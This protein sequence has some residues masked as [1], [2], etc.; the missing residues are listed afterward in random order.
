MTR[1]EEL[2]LNL[3]DDALTD[4]EARE[5]RA[6]LAQSEQARCTHIRLLHVEAALRAGGQG[7]D[8]A[9]AVMA[10]LRRQTADSVVHEV[11]SQI[12]KAPM[13]EWERARTS[14]EG[15]KRGQPL[16]H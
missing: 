1:L 10:R 7:P 6:L 14:E 5:L 8:L 13:P 11:M 4:A 9:A 12:R 3:A 2:T 16:G 15:H